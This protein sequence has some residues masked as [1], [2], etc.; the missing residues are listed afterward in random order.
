[1]MNMGINRMVAT[2]SLIVSGLI[3]YMDKAPLTM[4]VAN[5]ITLARL[6]IERLVCQWYSMGPKWR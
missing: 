4:M 3:K 1:M 2:T 6:G 5:A